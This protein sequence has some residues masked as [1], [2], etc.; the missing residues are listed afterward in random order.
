MS[1]P[2]PKSL[3][4]SRKLKDGSVLVESCHDVFTNERLAVA[5]KLAV[6]WGVDPSYAHCH[7]Y[8]PSEISGG[9]SIPRADL[10]P[11]I[12]WTP[13]PQV[14][15]PVDVTTYWNDSA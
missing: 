6:V 1:I 12:K 15:C 3:T 13:S 5:V 7:L 2:P 9:R 8:G 14:D 10:G 11:P 4:F